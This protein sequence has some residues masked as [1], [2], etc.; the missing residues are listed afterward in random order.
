MTESWNFQIIRTIFVDHKFHGFSFWH[1]NFWNIISYTDCTTIVYPFIIRYSLS[2]LA[3]RVYGLG[4]GLSFLTHAPVSFP[5]IKEERVQASVF[6]LGLGLVWTRV[7][8]R[9]AS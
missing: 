3:A 1:S 7:F 4:P 6:T 9:Y 8:E 5:L 2:I